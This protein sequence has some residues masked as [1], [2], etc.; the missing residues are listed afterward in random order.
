[1]DVTHFKRTVYL[2]I[3]SSLDFEECAH[4]LMKSGI[5]EGYEIEV[6]KMIIECCAQEKTYRRFY[7]LLAQRFAMLKPVFR[8][9]LAHTCFPEQVLIC[10]S[11]YRLS[12]GH[13]LL[14]LV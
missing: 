12:S 5:K 13:V 1:M 8:E 14:R 3:M 4:K 6:M 10:T 9:L 11:S 2:T 7:G